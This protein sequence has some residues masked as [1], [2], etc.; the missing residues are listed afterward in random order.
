[1]PHA[2]PTHPLTLLA[3]LFGRSSAVSLDMATVL[4]MLPWLRQFHAAG[5]ARGV[6][7]YSRAIAPLRAFAVE[8][9]LDLAHATNA[10]RFYRQGAG[11][12][13]TARRL[14]SRQAKPNA[15]THECLAFPIGK[16]RLVRSERWSLA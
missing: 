8:E 4:R 6:E 13:F 7:T 10:N 14:P 3:I 12:I 15:N 9:H 2:V 16:C 11:C 1:M 5:N